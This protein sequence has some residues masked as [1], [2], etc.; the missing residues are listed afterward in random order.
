M[1]TNRCDLP[2]LVEKLRQEQ[3]F[4]LFYNTQIRQAVQ[5]INQSCDNVFQSLWLTQCLSHGLDKVK[6]HHSQCV[7]W[8]W[9]LDQV[10]YVEFVDAAKILRSNLLV[11]SYS[12]FLSALLDGPTVLAHV[13]VWAESEGLDCTTLIS[14]VMS[15]IYGHCVF[16]RDHTLFLSL[17]KELLR[18]LVSSAESPR[19]LFSGV[20]PIFCRILSEYCIHLESLQTFL[21]EAFQQPLADI[22]LCEEYLEFDVSKAGSRLTS[23][24]GTD[25]DRLIDESNFLFGEDLDSNCEHLAEFAMHFIDGIHRLADQFPLSLKWVLGS[26]RSLVHTKWPHISAVE[27]RRP[28][29][30]VLFGPILGST[31]VNPDSHG[32]CDMEVVVSPVARYNLSQVAS[33]LQG[34]AWVLGRQVGKYPMQKVIKKMNT[35]SHVTIM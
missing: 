26:L 17:L 11:E 24:E 7:E 22:F 5:D 2:S 13:L 27:L 20:E 1:S 9:A 31:I 23:T 12:K 33:V 3:E 6:L 30:S 34:C 10:T 19:D 8:T 28:I 29:S 4:S 25:G 18:H 35:V 32:L 14:D 21:T 16:H 15:V